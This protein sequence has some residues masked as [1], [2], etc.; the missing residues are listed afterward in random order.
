MVVQLLTDWTINGSSGSE[1]YLVSL[2]SGAR[3]PV[4][5]RAVIHF[6]TA[7][8]LR[9]PEGC[10]TLIHPTV[11][12]GSRLSYY[13]LDRASDGTAGKSPES[14]WSRK[15]KTGRL[16]ECETDTP[17]TF[18]LPRGAPLYPPAGTAA[19]NNMPYALVSKVI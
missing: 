10:A 5:G 19:T 11:R 7:C 14:A 6:V 15:R 3:I 2:G 4:E 9:K 12:D 8:P 13:R 17:R 1:R 16:A 18:R